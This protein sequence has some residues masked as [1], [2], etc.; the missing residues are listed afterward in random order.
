[1]HLLHHV[2]PGVDSKNLLKPRTYIYIYICNLHD[3]ES[4]KQVSPGVNCKSLLNPIYISC[5]SSFNIQYLFLFE[6]KRFSRCLSLSP[7][8]FLILLQLL[9]SNFQTNPVVLAWVEVEEEESVCVSVGHN[10]RT[11]VRSRQQQQQQ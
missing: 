3:L 11:H 6:R 2:S 7:F 9:L 5:R 1:M 4:Q 8:H 10:I